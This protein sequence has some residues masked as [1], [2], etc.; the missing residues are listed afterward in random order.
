MGKKNFFVVDNEL[1]GPGLIFLF[2]GILVSLFNYLYHFFMGRML[3]PE[4]Y[5]ILGSVFAIVYISTFTSN[6]LNRV[7][8]K[9]VSEFKSKNQIGFIN[10]LIKKGFLKI[11]T[12]GFFFLIIYILITPF[13]AQYMNLSSTDSLIIAGIIAYFSIIL[14]L[15]TG[16]LNGIQKF[17]WQNLSNIVSSLLKFFLAVILVYLGYS[18]NGALFAIVIGIVASIVIC[19][20]PLMDILKSV[21]KEFYTKKVYVYAAYVFI[22]SFLSILLI[23][24][25]QILVKHYLSSEKAGLY[26]ALGNI[27]KI[28]WF[29]SGFLTGVI[30][31]KIVALHYGKKDVLKILKKSIFITLFIAGMLSVIYFTIPG[32]I[33]N[34]S[35]GEKYLE[36]KDLIGFFGIGMVMYSLIQLLITYNLAIERYGFIYIIF[37]GLIIEIFGIIFYHKTLFDVTKIFVVTNTIILML[38]FFYNKEILTNGK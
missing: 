14:T 10:Y 23:S 30:F 32:F 3:G 28:I 21:K 35:Y 8:S 34:L 24:L 18:V 36:I 26:I 17:G 16:V 6:S 22:A 13:I 25:D 12:F 9:F 31:P 5:G 15:F 11:L 4:D 37:F 29:S 2:S 27:G 38:M 1:I 20:F 33:I 19:Y 7:I